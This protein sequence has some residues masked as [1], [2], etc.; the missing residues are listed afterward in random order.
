MHKYRAHD[1]RIFTNPKSIQ[2]ELMNYGPV[3]TGFM[4][5]E[6]FMHHTGGIYRHRYGNL[7]GGHAVKI[8]GWGNE[9]GTDYWIVQ[10]SWGPNWAENGFFRI[11]FGEVNIDSMCIAGKPFVFSQNKF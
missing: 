9:N 5:Y 6:D 10:N 1:V 8:V 11:A 3:E 4:V 2:L 7:I